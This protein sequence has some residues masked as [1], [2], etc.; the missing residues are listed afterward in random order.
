MAVRGDIYV[1]WYASPRII[2]IES[3]SVELTIQDL[4]DTCRSLEADPI[5]MAYPYLI[6]AA[7]KDALAVGVEV[8]ITAT[9]Q[10]AVVAFED[11]PG[12]TFARCT[13]R[14]GNLLAVDINNAP[15]EPI[16]V[17]DFTQVKVIL[18]A[19][20]TIVDGGAGTGDWTETEKNQIRY[21]IGI[22]GSTNVPTAVPT[23]A[24]FDKQLEI[25]D[26]INN[27]N[28]AS[29]A[30]NASAYDYVLTTG[31]VSSGDITSVRALD[32]IYHILTDAAGT[33]DFYYKVNIG[34][35]AFPASLTAYADLSGVGDT[36]DVFAWNWVTSSWEPLGT[37]VGGGN[38]KITPQTYTML[39]AHVGTGSNIGEVWVRYYSNTL[40]SATLSIDFLYVSYAIV[41][42]RLGF[43]GSVVSATPT[44]VTL[45]NNASSVNN[46]Y[47]PSLCVVTDGT[48]KDQYARVESYDGATRTCTVSSAWAVTPD[49]TSTIQ[50]APWGSASVAELAQGAI[51]QIWDELLSTHNIP[52][53]TADKLRKTLSTGTFIALK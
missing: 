29:S 39:Q 32:E 26:A 7:G 49:S 6:S 23:L 53:S 25:L 43:A 38:F 31:N 4:V 27:I 21:R 15:I 24:T 11:R 47:V 3:P 12:P 18:S 16:R 22:D 20:A 46:Y 14:D 5:N 37:R 40:T 10:N 30:I 1:D 45:T 48:G 19:S 9:L 28:A 41:Y 17:T 50:L 35:D 33:L 51:D 2:W 36:L 42:P 8:G 52:G 34:R 44:S 13:V